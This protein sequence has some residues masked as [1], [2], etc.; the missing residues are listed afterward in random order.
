MSAVTPQILLDF[1]DTGFVRRPRFLTSA[2]ITEV[3]E[4]LDRV[5]RDVVPGLPREAAFYEDRERPETLK[6]IQHLEE[7]DG[8]F[9]RWFEGRFRDLAQQLLGCE[10]AGKNFQYFNKPPGVGQATPPHQDGYYFMIEPCV[11]ITMWLALEDVDEE[12]GC[13]RYVRGS[14]LREMRPHGRTGTL[15]F[16]QG[17][18]DFPAESDLANETVC[19]AKAGDLFAHHAKTI[20][21]AGANQSQTRSRQAIGA[22]YFAAHAKVDLDAQAAYQKKLHDDLLRDG[23][24]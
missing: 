18:T 19:P 22:V 10:V 14:H 11:A 24:I 13:L 15:G 20:H 8:Y 4:N 5:S 3:R 21:W 12:N 6:Q 17:V 23:K 9:R 1:N 2:E 16:S 7:H